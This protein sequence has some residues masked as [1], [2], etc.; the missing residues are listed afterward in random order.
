MYKYSTNKI[1]RVRFESSSH[2]FIT[3]VLVLN[4]RFGVCYYITITRPS[5]VIVAAGPSWEDVGSKWKVSWTEI[6]TF[7]NACS[8]IKT[9]MRSSARNN[10]RH[11][12]RLI[13]NE[14]VHMYSIQYNI[15][16]YNI[17][18]TY[19]HTPTQYTFIISIYYK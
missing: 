13:I 19:M 8:H 1:C 10:G 3:D 17:S 15:C 7:L 6:F 4:V 2:A 18:N 9:V 16:M 14:C 11:A 5:S 12:I